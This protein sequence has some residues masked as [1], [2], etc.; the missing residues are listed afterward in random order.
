M[1]DDS[2]DE[3]YVDIDREIEVLSFIF[4]TISRSHFYHVETGTIGVKLRYE[5]T[6]SDIDAIDVLLEY[7]NGYPETPPRIWV[8]APEIDPRSDMVVE[9]DHRNDA[10]VDYLDPDDWASS[11]NGFHAAALMKA[12]VAEY[13]H[14]LS[15]TEPSDRSLNRIVEELT[16]SVDSYRSG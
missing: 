16:A 14:W 11:M 3:V 13:C 6:F 5:P 7:P 15:N 9:F 2:R 1:R 10:R 8:T 12:W 4:P